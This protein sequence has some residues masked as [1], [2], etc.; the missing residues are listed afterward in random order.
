MV[1]VLRVITR[2]QAASGA[3]D[4][5]FRENGRASNMTRIVSDGPL[6]LADPINY[7]KPSRT[8]F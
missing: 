8:M 7:I 2:A 4:V 3:G 6:R 1:V 5:K